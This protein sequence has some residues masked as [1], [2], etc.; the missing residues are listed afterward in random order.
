MN[1]LALRFDWLLLG[2]IVCLLIFSLLI[3]WSIAP[4]VFPEQ[5]IFALFGLGLFFV[6]SQIDWRIYPGLAWLFYA[7]SLAILGVTFIFGTVSRGAVRWIQIGSLTIQPSE[8]AKPLLILF[9]AYFFSREENLSLK[10][11]LWGGLLL[12][13]PAILVFAQPDLGSAIIISLFWLAIVLG[14]GLSGKWLAAGAGLVLLM[15][16]LAWRFLKDYQRQRIYTFLNP[17]LDPL[18]S[19]YNIIQSIIAVGSGQLFGRDLGMGTQSHLR[20]LPER[21]SDFIFASIAE[22]LGFLGVGVLLVIFVLLLWRILRVAQAAEDRFAMLVCLGVFAM[23]FGQFFI[24]AGM[25]LGLL[26]VTGIT[27]PLVSSGGSSLV[28]ILV[29]LGLVENV[30]GFIGKNEVKYYL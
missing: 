30:A 29:S 25:N 16:P 9:F 3:I 8:L 11:A 7:A 15:L 17:S 24:N 1:K 10:R 27:L 28:A 5:L 23:V 19:G 21:H 20:F 26:P 12:L 4:A 22:E 6:F 13:L 2:A 18:H 14:A